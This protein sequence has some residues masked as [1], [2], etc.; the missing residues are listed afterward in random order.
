MSSRPPGRLWAV[1][2][3]SVWISRYLP[4]ELPQLMAHGLLLTAAAL[5]LRHPWRF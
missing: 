1:V 4:S 3:A 2:D 5:F